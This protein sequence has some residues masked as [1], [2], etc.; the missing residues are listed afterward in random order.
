MKRRG[1][2]SEAERDNPSWVLSY[3]PELAVLRGFADRIYW[4]FD[5]PKDPYRAGRRR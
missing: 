3:L 2:V 4:L 1:H 5:T